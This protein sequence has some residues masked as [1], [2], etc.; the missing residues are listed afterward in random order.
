MKNLIFAFIFITIT[1]TAFSQ[2]IARP[3]V[4]TGANFTNFTNSDSDSKTTLY[5]GGFLAIKLAHF[6]TL[7]PEIN[8]SRQGAKSKFSSDYDTEIQYIGL[9][10]TNKFSPFKGMGL[11]TIIGPGINIK[12]GD[13]YDTNFNDDLEGFD[14]LIFGGLG[15]DFPFGLGAEI[16]Y[17]IGLIDIFGRNINSNNHQDTTFDNLILNKVFQIGVTYKFDF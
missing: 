6:Y 5:V 14:F 4:R 16:R 1:T 7:Q 3:G 13:N 11:Y 15:Y 8:Y 10:I 17:N 12:V 2:V 9:A